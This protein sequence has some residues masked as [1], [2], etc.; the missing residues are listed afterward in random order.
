MGARLYPPPSSTQRP[1]RARTRARARA[2]ARAR[3]RAQARARA[4]A[5][6]R[7]QA[8]ARAQARARARAQPRHAAARQASTTTIANTRSGLPDVAAGRSTTLYL[9]DDVDIRPV[10]RRCG[11]HEI[12]TARAGVLGAAISSVREFLL[13]HCKSHLLVKGPEHA[14]HFCRYQLFPPALHFR[15]CCMT[16]PSA[17]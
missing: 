3:A 1:L 12:P 15:S 10:S 4:R 5:R 6:A 2:Q 14:G 16:P 8:Q 7:A 11:H 13:T 17:S 9:S